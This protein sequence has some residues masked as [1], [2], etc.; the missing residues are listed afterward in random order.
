MTDDQYTLAFD[1]A[2]REGQLSEHTIENGSDTFTD[3]V[4][5]A[6]FDDALGL[7]ELYEVSAAN[8]SDAVYEGAMAAYRERLDAEIAH[9]HG[10]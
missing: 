9:V 6:A 3:S 8:I 1:I 7:E 4:H 2:K 10:L 5:P